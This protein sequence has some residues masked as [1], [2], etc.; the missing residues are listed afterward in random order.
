MGSDVVVLTFW[1]GV[2]VSVWLWCRRRRRPD[3]DPWSGKP[4]ALS[5]PLLAPPPV[6]GAPS[7]AGPTVAAASRRRVLMLTTGT[8][9]DVQPIVAMGAALRDAGHDVVVCTNDPFEAFVTSYGLRFASNGSE[10]RGVQPP[11]VGAG[12]R[13]VSRSVRWACYGMC[14]SPISVA[15]PAWLRACVCGCGVHAV[16]PNG[17]CVFDCSDIRLLRCTHYASSLLRV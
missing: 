1:V 4:W 14:G 11:P 10:W 2:V 9:G 12:R 17:R 16:A 3:A 8:R 13:R 15:R 7:P 6:G 5:V